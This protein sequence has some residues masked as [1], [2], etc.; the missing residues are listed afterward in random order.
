MKTTFVESGP[1]IPTIPAI[2]AEVLDM[3]VRSSEIIWPRQT[4]MPANPRVVRNNK[5][6]FKAIKFC[7]QLL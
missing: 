2:P 5:S 7:E 3:R 4:E 6:M 1:A